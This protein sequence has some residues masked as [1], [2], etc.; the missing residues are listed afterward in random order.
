MKNIKQIIALTLVSF[1]LIFTAFKPSAA[2]DIVG[3]WKEESGVRVIEIYKDGEHY[4]GKILKNDHQNEDKLTVGKIF[5]ENF[6][7]N[8][9]N[10]SWEGKVNIPSKNMTLKTE[11]Q[12]DNPNQMKSIAHLGIFKKAKIWKRIGSSK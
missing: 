6:I 12:L 1:C 2:N 3:K 9:D 4:F 10:D 8:A 7:Y 11:I 5:M